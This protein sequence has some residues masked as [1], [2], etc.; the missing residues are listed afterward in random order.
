MC[1]FRQ[2][3]F[4][5]VPLKLTRLLKSNRADMLWCAHAAPA[6]THNPAATSA[7]IREFIGI[8]LVIT[9]RR[10]VQNR[11]FKER[12]HISGS[13]SKGHLP[14]IGLSTAPVSWFRIVRSVT[15]LTCP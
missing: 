5:S 4:V 12:I 2:S 9:I 10:E 15:S 3:Y 6:A 7:H 14:S 1:G 11:S 8:L 13:E